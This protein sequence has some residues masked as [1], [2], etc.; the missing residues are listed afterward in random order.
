MEDVHDSMVGAVIVAECEI[1]MLTPKTIVITNPKESDFV[2]GLIANKKHGIES[3]QETIA[4]L[5][6]KIE[7]EKKLQIKNK[8]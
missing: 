5:E 1:E 8:K 4:I 2:K 3:M 7:A 6:D